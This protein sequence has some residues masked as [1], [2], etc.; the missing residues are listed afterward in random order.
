M[1]SATSVTSIPASR[2][3]AAVPP[4]ERISTPSSASPLAKS[5]TPVLSET[6]I[7]A[8]RT[9][10]LLRSALTSLSA[11]VASAEAASSA[12]V[13]VSLTHRSATRRGLRASIL[14]LPPAIMRIAS[15]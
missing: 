13:W 8:R 5:A 15:G 12:A 3:A 6:E 10:T 14:T 7:S 11:A 1:N 9:R 4:V 2:S